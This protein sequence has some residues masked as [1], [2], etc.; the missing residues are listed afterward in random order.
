M[1]SPPSTTLVHL[2]QF[3]FA[4]L[5][6][7]L[8]ICALMWPGLSWIEMVVPRSVLQFVPCMSDRDYQALVE[9]HVVAS[10]LGMTCCR[11]NFHSS[12]DG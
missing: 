8:L 7:D 3:S 11:D 9:M 4:H 5:C 2:V 6:H 1:V 10:P 12:F